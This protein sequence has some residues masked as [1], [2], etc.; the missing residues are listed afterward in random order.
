MRRRAWDDGILKNQAL[1]GCFAG[2][3]FGFLNGPR[4]R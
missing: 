2:G 4:G 3:S 1:H